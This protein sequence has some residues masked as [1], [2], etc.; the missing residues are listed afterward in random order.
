MC[1]REEAGDFSVG[2]SAKFDWLD[3]FPR[4]GERAS[5]DIFG[6]T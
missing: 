1:C 6:N 4:V 2:C 5:D 3:L